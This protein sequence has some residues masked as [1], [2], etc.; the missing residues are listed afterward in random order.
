MAS[1]EEDALTPRIKGLV[2]RS[3]VAAFP[4]SFGKAGKGPLDDDLADNGGGGGGRDASTPQR[5]VVMALAKSVQNTT[6]EADEVNVLTISAHGALFRAW[7][8]AARN[9]TISA[10][11]K[12]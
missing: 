4:F 12:R 9:H 5:D 1:G 11:G 8:F 3:A 10:S 7:K 6:R 2:S